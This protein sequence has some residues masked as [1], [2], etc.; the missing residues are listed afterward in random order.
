MERVVRESITY[1]TPEKI[2]DNDKT[3]I[4]S[5]ESG[6][7]EESTGG[8]TTGG[9]AG[10]ETNA[11]VSEYTNTTGDTGS[12]YASESYARDYLVNQ[13]KEQ[14][15]IDPGV[16]EDLTVSV[17]VNG[18][19][20]GNLTEAE[21]RS[22]VANA[23]G[24]AQNEQNAK[25]TIVAAPFYE[26]TTPTETATFIQQYLPYFGAGLG[27]LLLLGVGLFLLL[28]RRRRRKA[29]MEEEYDEDFFIPPVI[30]PEEEDEKP[31]ILNLKS[32]KTREL[33]ETVRNFAN[34][35][36]EISAQMLKSWL[37]GGES[38]GGQSNG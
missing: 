32:E 33:R 16:L 28:R 5:S 24:I 12:T 15:E 36:P 29:E 11:D 21:A 25:I 8:S 10:T 4:I 34:D 9:V 27:L 30:E 22:L 6:S 35:N 17:S 3:G 13:I 1:E 18:N 26:E 38:D 23:T 19:T 14:G 37:N 7:A 31:E 2:N 20:L